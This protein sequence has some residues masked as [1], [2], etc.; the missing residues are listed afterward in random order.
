MQLGRSTDAE[1]RFEFA[2]GPGDYQLSG[3]VRGQPIKLTIPTAEPP[4][5]IVQDFNL[6]RQ[7]TGP[8]T[9]R[10]VGADGKPAAA[11]S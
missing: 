5:E 9:V 4:R 10:V 2:V 11:R 8:F 6:P 3:P 1:G 7:L